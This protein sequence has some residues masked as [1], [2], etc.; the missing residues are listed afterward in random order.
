M[1]KQI[2][3][4]V[5]LFLLLGAVMANLAA[6]QAVEPRYAGVSWVKADLDISTSGAASCSGEVKLKSGYTA[7]LKVLLKQ[8]GTA[9]KTWTSS[10]SG[11]VTAGGTYYVTSGHDYVVTATAT[12]YDSRGLVVEVV[13]KNAT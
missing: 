6:V 12:V 8:D 5:S 9:I 4:A 11:T 2:K 7:D 1:K 10:G 3:S 13:S